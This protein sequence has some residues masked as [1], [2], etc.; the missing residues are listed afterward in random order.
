[1][2]L[3]H[4]S[5]TSGAVGR[6]T[7]PVWR[8]ER[9]RPL[10]STLVAALVAV[11]AVLA[12]PSV[13]QAD[14]SIKLDVQDVESHAAI[15]DFTYLISED[16]AARRTDPVGQRPGVRPTPSYIPQASAGDDSTANRI[17]LADGRY[18]V[19]VKAPGYKLWGKHFEGQTGAANVVVEMKPHPL[20]LGRLVVHA[21]HDRRP[22]NAAPDFVGGADG[23]G[24]PASKGSRSASTTRSARC[25][26]TTTA[27]RC[28]AASA[29]PAPTGTSR[30]RTSRRAG[31]RSRCSRRTAR[32]GCRRPRSR[33]RT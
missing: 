29:S 9:C 33:A 19:T 4:A 27:T 5:R 12:L 8:R 15:T 32:T 31:T 22:V 25:R 18:L 23:G 26:P 16:N 1:M 28:A 11:L 7:A 10:R 24:E 2:P 14:F 20:P 17:S 3:G 21:F 13:A 30:S 6:A